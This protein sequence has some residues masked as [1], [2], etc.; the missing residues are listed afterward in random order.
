MNKI[1][2]LK[3]NLIEKKKLVEE[4]ENDRYKV[5]FSERFEIL[6]NTKNILDSYPKV[7]ID[8]VKLSFISSD[9]IR[10]LGVIEC[11]SPDLNNIKGINSIKMGSYRKNDVLCQTCFQTSSTCS[12]HFGYIELSYPF[13]NP[14]TIEYIKLTLECICDECGFLNLSSSLKKSF[15]K[16]NKDTYKKLKNIS[17][18][19]SGVCLNSINGSGLCSNTT[20]KNKISYEG[21]KT[22]SN[23]GYKVIKNIKVNNTSIIQ[24]LTSI[25]IKNIFKRISFYDLNVMGFENGASPV[26]FILEVLPVLP[27]RDRPSTVIKNLIKPDDLTIM[28]V[29]IIKKNIDL[30]KEMLNSGSSGGGS[31][32]ADEDKI[33]SI[34]KQLFN[35]IKYI[36]NN[37]KGVKK[38]NN[39]NVAKTINTRLSSKNGLC[40]NGSQAKRVDYAGRSVIDCANCDFGWVVLPE[41]FRDMTIEEKVFEMNLERL[42]EMAES[43]D[44]IKI[45]KKGTSREFYLENYFKFNSNFSSKKDLIEIGDTVIRKLSLG[46]DVFINRQPSL[47]RHS[48]I[49]C[50]SIFQKNVFAIKLHMSYTEP[51]NADFD[52]DEIN[53]NVPQTIESRAELRHLMNANHQIINITNST[54]IFKPIFNDPTSAYLISQE[55]TLYEILDKNQEEEFIKLFFEDTN[56]KEYHLRLKKYNIPRRTP[57]A[58]FSLLFPKDFK[59]KDKIVEGIYVGGTLNKDDISKGVI[60]ALY[61]KY[62]WFCVSKFL[63]SVRYILDYFIERRGFTIGLEDMLLKDYDNQK[64]EF[65]EIISKIREDVLKIERKN[66]FTEFEKKN[67]TIEIISSLLNPIENKFGELITKMNKEKDNNF[68]VMVKSKAKGS[69]K[70]ITYVMATVGQQLVKGLRPSKSVYGNR[71]LSYFDVGD[72]DLESRGFSVNSFVEGLDPASYFFQAQSSRIGLLDTAL[73]TGKIGALTKHISKITENEIATYDGGV[74]DSSGNYISLSY[75]DGFDRGEL[76][77]SEGDVYFPFDLNGI[78]IDLDLI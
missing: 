67:K 36:M 1:S 46:D 30:K 66:V 77:K 50:R 7:S 64:R 16:M 49:G 68:V 10:K 71:S 70:N 35:E 2:K 76:V 73:E 14:L 32:G 39:K 45:I 65:N 38:L 78:L 58:V 47:H 48:M 15:L 12:G 62:G 27:E 17:K 21:V 23:D 42:K 74:C 25:E 24:V 4:I 9:T 33:N 53:I 72:I 54:P 29:N 31:A 18:Y 19:V 60:S 22:I 69:F 55:K 13:F 51:L 43:D 44:I 28:Y 56:I 40:R 57:Q 6:K 41:K 20:P 75:D 34:K 8:A 59:Y 52:G 37:N 26:N 61:I 3:E 5:N 11:S 63:T